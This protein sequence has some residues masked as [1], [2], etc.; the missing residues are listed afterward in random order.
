MLLTSDER[1][2]S[3]RLD[4]VK[5]LGRDGTGDRIAKINPEEKIISVAALV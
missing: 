1:V 5:L 2:V 3:L 4:S